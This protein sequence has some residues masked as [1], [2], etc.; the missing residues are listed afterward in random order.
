MTCST[1]LTGENKEACFASGRDSKQG[2]LHVYRVGTAQM[3]VVITV[4]KGTYAS[5]FDPEDRKAHIIVEDAVTQEQVADVRTDMNG[6]LRALAAAQ[7]ALPLHGGMWTQP[8]R[9]TGHG[10][11]STRQQSRRLSPGAE[12]D[13]ERRPRKARHPQ[14]LRRA[15]GRATSSPWPWTRSSAVRRLDVS[16]DSDPVAQAPAV[17][18]PVADVLTAAGF[19]GDVDKAAAVK[20]AADDAAELE[21]EAMDLDSRSKEALVIAVEAL[22]DADRNTTEAEQ[23]VAEA[24]NVENEEQR[25]ALMVEAARSRQRA[26]E[27]GMRARAAQRTAEDLANESLA[28]K[29]QAITA[30]KLAT[31]VRTTIGAGRDQEALPHLIALKKQ[32]DSRVGPTATP[33]AAERTRR[34]VTE[35][36]VLAERAMRQVQAKSTEENELTARIGR[37]KRDQDATGSRSKKDELQKEINVLEEQLSALRDETRTAKAAALTM[38]RETAVL[39]GQ[40]SLTRHLST[41]ATTT[42]STVPTA[43]ADALPQRIAATE[44]RMTAL[45]IDER[46]EALLNEPVAAMEARMFNW[47]L[48][49]A[50]PGVPTDRTTTQ[51][52]DRSTGTD[53]QQAN[54]RTAAMQPGEAARAGVNDVNVAQ[55]PVSQD[56]GTDVEASDTDINATAGSDTASR[57]V[58]VETSTSD[59]NTAQAGTEQQARTEDQRSGGTETARNAAAVGAVVSSRCRTRSRWGGSGAGRCQ[60]GEHRYTQHRWQRGC[61][62]G[63]RAQRRSTERR[64]G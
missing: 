63:Q 50:A 3:P 49:S 11:S 13:A 41:T 17:E 32:H 51:T 46:Y 22:E 40:A 35:Q 18:E 4:L 30:A 34:A 29:Q 64:S 58:A 20:L 33:D 60:R 1:S 15:A 42:T 36:Q 39:R 61:Q 48:V 9:P 53:A 56:G 23:L 5:A 25:N 19:T 24:A 31:D 7:R 59:A 43:V 14:L 38:E 21:R 45:A 62:H 37:L 55:V 16:T 54:V 28:T 10:G 44:S 47:D 12:P 8:E 2:M 26:R 52:A 27:S 57:D 6:S